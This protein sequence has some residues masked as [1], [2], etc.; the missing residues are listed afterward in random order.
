[1]VD[2]G[3]ASV[4]VRRVADDQIVEDSNEESYLDDVRP[5]ARGRSQR[6]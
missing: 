3:Q 1:M 4:C 6:L 2:V 5:A